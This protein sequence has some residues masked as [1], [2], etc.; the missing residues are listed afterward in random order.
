[1]IGALKMLYRTVVFS[2]FLSWC[3]ALL[4]EGGELDV[5]S[6]ARVTNVFIDSDLRYTLQDIASQA[7]VNI[8]PDQ[9]VGGIVTAEIDD[10][11]V[12]DA[13][14][15]VLAGTGFLVKRTPN[16]FLVY[17]PDERSGFFHDVTETRLVKT[18]YVDVDAARRLLAPAF[19]NYLRAD[20]GSGLIAV[21][22]PSG[23]LDRIVADIHALDQPL[24]H[25]MLDARVVVLEQTDALNLGVRWDWP[26]IRTGTYS[27]DTE[28]SRWPWGVQIGYTPGREFTRSLAMNLNL[29]VQNQRATVVSSPQLL[30]QDTREAQIRV[31]T[32]E[33][34]EI[35]TEGVFVRSQLE[36]IESGTILKITPRIGDDNKITLNM[37]IEVSDV[38]ARGRSDLPVVSRRTAQSTVRIESGGTAAVGGLTASNVQSMQSRVPGVGRVPLMGRLFRDDASIGETKQVAVFVTATL[39]SEIEDQT[40]FDDRPRRL[41]PVKAEEFT[42]ELRQALERLR[43]EGTIR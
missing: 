39:L 25:V 40:V 5:Q 21:T 7:G 42:E 28:Q 15:L 35:L 30:A 33:Y 37:E 36:K 10:L 6:S 16:Y 9:K 19:Q 29:L 1:M 18:N 8:I 41:P 32:E 3:S 26:E 2:L 17:D 38:V 13:L 31:T 11:P 43:E 20:S 4:L 22:A 12:E 34:F 24:Q 14:E 27:N 23:I